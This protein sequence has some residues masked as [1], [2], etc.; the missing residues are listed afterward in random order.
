MY[1]RLA[2]IVTSL[3]ALGSIF[4]ESRDSIHRHLQQR[5]QDASMEQIARS[6]N[7]LIRRWVMLNLRDVQYENKV[8]WHQINAIH[9][10]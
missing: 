7:S 4:D 9:W 8:Q 10:R 1:K 2:E 3:L 5:F 6:V